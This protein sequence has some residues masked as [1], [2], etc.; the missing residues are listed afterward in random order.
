VAV[1]WIAIFYSV[2]M[3]VS[4]SGS[5]LFGRLFDRFGFFVLIG[6]TLLSASF[7]P[8][9]FL[10]GF[11]IALIGA[12]I[13]G[14]GIGLHESIIPAAVTPMVPIERRASAFGLLPPAMACS[15]FSPARPSDFSTI[16]RCRLRL[17]SAS[18][19]NSQPVPIFIWVGRH[20]YLL[21]KD[22]HP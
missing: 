12:A 7:A 6:L 19:L 16:S 18:P 15:G 9:V 17:L 11:W 14:L 3:A 20:I 21:D 5:L 1:D 8:L 2:A 4:G 10:G 13:W 22:V